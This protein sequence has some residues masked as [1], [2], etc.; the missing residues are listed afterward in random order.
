VNSRAVLVDDVSRAMESS[1]QLRSILVPVDGS[2]FAEQAIPLALAVAERARCRIRLVL[3]HHQLQPL[4][5]LEPQF[6]YVSKRLAIKRSEREYLNSLVARLGTHRDPMLSAAY[7]NGP[8]ALTLAEYIRDIGVDLVVMSS[9]G[10]GGIQRAWLGSVADQL[11]RTLEIPILLVRPPGEESCSGSP[12]L[13][14]ILVPL[15]GSELAEA[16][17]GSAVSLA[18]LWN[19]ELRLV[20]VVHPIALGMGTAL[21]LP[22]FQQE[23]T[24]GGRQAAQM[25]LDKV[26]E[27]LKAQ[28]LKASG[29]AVIGGLAA[30]SILRLARTE[31]ADAIAIATHGRGGVRRF[32]L[33]SVAD[34][35][36]RGA[37]IPILVHRP[38]P[39]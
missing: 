22:S 26:A 3:V 33:G 25:Y 23:L 35:L 17:L 37:E 27:V 11:V 20:Q 30:G 32:L 31:E 12:R 38:S 29:T 34:K 6:D 2:E 5:P 19:S 28:G 1:L 15:D 24:D 10:R 18:R 36:V 8:V 13:Q 16:I 9:H 7:L 4:F 39:A 14:K 21:S